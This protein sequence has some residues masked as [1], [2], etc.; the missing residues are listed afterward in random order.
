MSPNECFV[1]MPYGEKPFP[2]GSGRVC[3]VNNK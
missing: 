3:T 2:D 1:V